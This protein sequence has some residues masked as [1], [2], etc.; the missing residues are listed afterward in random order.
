MSI[1]LE[2]SN[3]KLEHELPENISLQRLND[4]AKE[5]FKK[6]RTRIGNMYC[7]IE[8]IFVRTFSL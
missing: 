7:K 2:C 4:E 1:K 8:N 6:H 5:F 3:C